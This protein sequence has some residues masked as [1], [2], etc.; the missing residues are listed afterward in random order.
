MRFKR[1]LSGLMAVAL[2]VSM[3]G[4]GG[5]NGGQTGSNGGG[6]GTVVAANK[7]SHFYRAE[8]LENLPAEFT[9]VNRA[10]FVGDNIFYTSNGPDYS[11]PLV[12]RINLTTGD[13]S[14][15]WK[16]SSADED[17]NITGMGADDD[18]NV[19]LFLRQTR[20]KDEVLESFADTTEDDIIDFLYED[21][22]ME[23]REDAEK[24]WNDEL[25]T[26]YENK[27]LAEIYATF[28][29]DYEN[30]YYREDTFLKF[31]ASGKELCN[32]TLDIGGDIEM[33]DV[34]IDK[35]GNVIALMGEWLEDDNLNYVMIFD[36][37]GNTKGK[38]DLD[39][40]SDSLIRLANGDIAVSNSGETCEI[41]PIDA[42]NHSKGEAKQLPGLTYISDMCAYS[43]NEYLVSIDSFVT[44][45]N[46]ETGE[47]EKF[48]T[49]LD[50][51][52]MSYYVRDFG[53][54]SDGSIGV[55]LESYG[56]NQSTDLV[57]L[58]E[59][60]E[61]EA[62][63][64]TTVNVV[65]FYA[66]S[67]LQN[68]ALEFNKKHSD[69]RVS[70][71]EYY[72]F[73]NED[74][75]YQDA[76]DTFVTDCA[77][78]SS[79]DVVSFP[80]YSQM[81]DFADKGLLTDLTPYMESDEV[82]KKENIIP[83]ILSAFTYKDKFVALP[84]SYRVETLLGKKSVVGDKP[85]WTVKDCLD[86]YNATGAM[87]MTPYTDRATIMRS[88]I[89]LN[90]DEFIDLE[91]GTCNFNNQDFQ[92]VLALAAKYPEEYK[93][94]EESNQM[95][96][97]KNGKQ[98][99][100]VTSLPE[101][102]LGQSLNSICG[103]DVTYIGYPTSNGNGAMMSFYGMTGITVN[104]KVPELMWEFMRYMYLP[105]SAEEYYAGSEYYSGSILNSELDKYLDSAKT[106]KNRGEMG[107]DTYSVELKTP[108]EAEVENMRD[109]L[110]NTTAVQDSVSTSI[111]NIISEE[112]AAYFTGEKTA[113]D[114][115]A[116][117]QSRVD[118]YL[119]ETK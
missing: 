6:E 72:D 96:D 84:S 62:S 103:E 3:A 107:Y 55:Y 69:Y 35:D 91:K 112:A 109:I 48:L 75:E 73:S 34:K 87:I 60:S 113:A 7:A 26:Y 76:M 65:C 29:A 89:S 45:V 100:Y 99:L 12:G 33:R 57:I 78:D 25:K 44:K 70:I 58:R 81:L 114:V 37:E 108:T 46:L 1:V 38:V 53:V 4:C 32:K 51:N 41:I 110:K 106:W 83:G 111:M 19:V 47:S 74:V 17:Q 92:D 116:V 97:F 30:D 20:L 31:D 90:Y 80:G 42:A 101:F 56:A 21:W 8:Y 119:S 9:E 40:Y 115:A 15:I 64:I 28:K 102:S 24:Y 105:D 11:T 61:E 10:C 13:N 43:D 77:T 82:L 93:Y 95:D 39:S 104:C 18:G 54:L 85:G 67:R 66:D 117:V 79:I 27:S 23:S 118:I 71:T 36:G 98:L 52:I 5:K 50:S 49:W 59:I 88:L 94:D 68:A 22:G 86:A 14:V 2:A 63:K 16:K